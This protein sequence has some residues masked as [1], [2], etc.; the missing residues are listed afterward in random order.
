M[1]SLYQIVSVIILVFIAGAC[2]TTSDMHNSRNSLDWAGDYRGTVLAGNGKEAVTVLSLRDDFT[3]N[4]QV[5]EAGN[6][7]KSVVSDGVFQWNKNGS[8]IVLKGLKTGKKTFKVVE[9]TLQEVT[10]KT[11]N[12]ALSMK[13]IQPEVITEK[14]WKLIEINGNP[15]VLDESMKR[16]PFI[17]LK[18]EEQRINGYGGC[19]TLSGSYKIEPMNRISFS[20]MISTMMACLHMETEDAMKRVFEMTDNYTLSADGKY[21]SLNRAR[22]APLARFEVV[23]LR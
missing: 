8:E 16:E 17:I 3:Y 14:Y 22:M 5:A 23:Y 1:K 7:D 19:N 4:M 11:A 20:Q 2:K 6:F 12:V 18:D 21:L 15:V 13:K 10:G 9:N